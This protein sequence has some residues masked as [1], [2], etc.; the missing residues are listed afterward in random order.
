MKSF[1]DPK[2]DIEIAVAENIKREAEKVER[3]QDFILEFSESNPSD[4]QELKN[5][6]IQIVEDFR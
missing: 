2:W 4:F 3:M 5:K 6:A 1:I